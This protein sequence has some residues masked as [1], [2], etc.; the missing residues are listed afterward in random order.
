MALVLNLRPT[1]QVTDEQLEQISRANPNLKLERSPEGELIVMALNGGETGRRNSNLT[2]QLWFWNQQAEF[3][4][5]FDSST[6]F[7]L[8]DGAIRSPDAAWI[9]NER[10]QTLTPTQKQKY[11]PLCPDFVVELRSSSDALEE[12]QAKMQEY[13]DNG[14]RLGWLIDP[15]SQTVEIY[16][17]SSPVE[18]L[19]K[20]ESLSGEDVLVGFSLKLKGILGIS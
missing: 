15:E 5:S 14:L 2:G 7:R 3:G 11:V 1:I 13:L 16:R 9:S 20:P 4:E 18:I 19:Q 6:G 10:W 12:L 17:P 8:P